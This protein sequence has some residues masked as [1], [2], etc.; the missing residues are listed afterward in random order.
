MEVIGNFRVSIFKNFRT[1]SGTSVPKA[2]V[3]EKEEKLSDSK[4]KPLKRSY[5]D[6]S[7]NVWYIANCSIEIPSV[8][9]VVTHFTVPTVCP[10]SSDPF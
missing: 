8:H 7:R 9:E 4:P 6:I 1:H 3:Q 10:R 5:S 2:P